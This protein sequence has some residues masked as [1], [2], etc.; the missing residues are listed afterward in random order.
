MGLGD[1]EAKRGEEEKALGTYGEALGLVL[2]HLEAVELEEE[3]EGMVEMM[4]QLMEVQQVAQL[5]VVK[6]EKYPY[7]LIMLI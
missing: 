4:V 1:I 6:M 7:H 2:R 5:E 3:E